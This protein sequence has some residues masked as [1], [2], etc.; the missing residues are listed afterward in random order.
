MS[1]HSSQTTTDHDTIRRWAEARGGKPAAVKATEGKSDPG[2]LRIAF[3][4]REDDLDIIDWNA[5]FEAFE[6]NEL[7]F[8]YQDKTKD[9]DESRFCKFVSRD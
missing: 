5:F 4:E 7:V 1:Q 9:G 2:L 8:L 6:A 3:D